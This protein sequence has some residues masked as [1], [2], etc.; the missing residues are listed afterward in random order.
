M[1]E[2]DFYEWMDLFG[3]EFEAHGDKGRTFESTGGEQVINSLIEAIR[4]EDPGVRSMGAEALQV[5]GSRLLT[6]EHHGWLRP[7]HG[8]V[9]PES[10]RSLSR[11]VEP[12]ITLLGDKIVSVRQFAAAALGKF[13]DKR[14]VEPLVATLWEDRSR[15]VREMAAEALGDIADERAVKPLVAA[16][17]DDD[18]GF[19]DHIVRVSAAYAL[20]SIGDKKAVN[21]LLDASETG[22]SKVRGAAAISLGKIGGAR[23]FE[24]LVTMVKSEGDYVRGSAAIGLGW[25]GDERAIDLL[26]EYR[27][28]ATTDFERENDPIANALKMLEDKTPQRE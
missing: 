23:V 14:A 6:V 25:L 4:D 9:S 7:S 17:K 3:K 21:A 28:T 8:D 11:A 10:R 22:D 16:L 19:D 2:A 15:D 5:I 1:T 20:G 24:R 13:G 12:L 26:K 18:F 27:T